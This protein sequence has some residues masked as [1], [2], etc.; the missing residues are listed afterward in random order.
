M[1]Y[2]VLAASSFVAAVWIWRSLRTERLESEPPYIPPNFPY[3]SHAI[4]LFLN[5]IP[6]YDQI[7]CVTF[8]DGKSASNKLTLFQQ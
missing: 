4:G 2:I 1:M 6:Y 8:R 3:F 5:K 7:K